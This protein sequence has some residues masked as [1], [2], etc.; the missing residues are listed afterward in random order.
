MKQF[1]YEITSH[2]ADVFKDVIYFCSEQGECSLETIPSDQ[3]KKMERILNGRGREG[4]EIVQLSFGKNGILAFW[5][6]LIGTT[7]T[8]DGI[9]TIEMSQA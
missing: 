2:P 6:R 4:W 7:H 5:K 8:R 3:I 1:E 9:D